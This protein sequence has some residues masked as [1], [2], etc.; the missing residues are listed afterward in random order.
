MRFNRWSNN[1]TIQKIFEKMQEM[2]IID[3]R[4]DIL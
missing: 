1:G 3:V 4:T 2:D